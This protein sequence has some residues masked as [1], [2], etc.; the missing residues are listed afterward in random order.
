MPGVHAVSSMKS[1]RMQDHFAE[2]T[3]PRHRAVTY[4]LIDVVVIAVCA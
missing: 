2:L 4:P 3:D 1:A